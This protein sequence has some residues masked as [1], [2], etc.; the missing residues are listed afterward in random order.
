VEQIHKGQIVYDKHRMLSFLYFPAIVF[1]GP[2]FLFLSLSLGFPLVSAAY[3]YNIP[4]LSEKE[5]V[6]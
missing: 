3:F 1:I 4:F 6:A 2:A 5:T